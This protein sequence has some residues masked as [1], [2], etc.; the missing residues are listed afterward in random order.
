L[1]GW[2]LDNTH[3]KEL[4]LLA[5]P[6]LG[7]HVAG[8]ENWLQWEIRYRKTDLGFLAKAMTDDDREHR[9][10]VWAGKPRQACCPQGTLRSGSGRKS[11]ISH[12][13]RTLHR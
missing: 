11:H 4:H 1:P 13:H 10:R 5:L 7:V 9:D 8:L 6:T 3:Q 12:T 2:H